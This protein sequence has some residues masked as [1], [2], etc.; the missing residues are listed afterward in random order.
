MLIVNVLRSLCVLLCSAHNNGD[1]LTSMMYIALIRKQRIAEQKMEKDIKKEKK[2][3]DKKKPDDGEKNGDAGKSTLE[4]M[5]ESAVKHSDGADTSSV[6]SDG[7]GVEDDDM[8]SVVKRRRQ[9]AAKAAE[10]KQKKEAEK[11]LL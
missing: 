6:P 7:A 9:L 5:L 3:K 10:E 11:K 8:L 4:K 2:E 1:I